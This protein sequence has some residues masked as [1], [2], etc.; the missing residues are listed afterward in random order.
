MSLRADL[1]VLYHLAVTRGRGASQQERLENFYR[2]QAGHYDDFRKR[3]L[4]GRQELVDAL[5]LEPGT[6][7]VDLGGGTG[8]N[9]EMAGRRL[10]ALRRVYVVDLCRPLLNVADERARRNGWQNVSVI[11][12]DATTFA[13]DEGQADIVTFSYSLTMIPEWYAAI[14]NARQMLRPGG[15][16]GVADFYV[17]QKHPAPGLVTHP[18]ATRKGWPAWFDNDN[19]YLSPDHLPWLRRHFDQVDLHEYRAPVPFIPLLR[20]PY[21]R[22]LGRKDV[23]Q[24]D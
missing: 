9:L 24:F 13:P 18:W 19:V 2:G 11:H 3:L 5:P 8:A 17:S 21:Y 12:A 14:E 4:H 1:Q 15:I 22:F 6:I 23:P 10:G 7:W 16:I 20:V